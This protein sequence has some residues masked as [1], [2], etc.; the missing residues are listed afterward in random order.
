METSTELVP[1]SVG[2]LIEN[3]GHDR[4]ESAARAMLRL[5]QRELPVFDEFGPGVYLRTMFIPAGT[6]IIG[7][8]HK[9][10][11]F[12][13][14]LKGSGLIFMD[15]VVTRVRAPATFL[16]EAG[17]QKIGYIDEDM[18]IQGIFPTDETDL[19]K[20]HAMLT[21]PSPALEEHKLQ[22]LRR[23]LGLATDHPLVQE[24]HIPICSDSPQ[25]K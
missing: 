4:I 9:T 22:F 2:R 14:V 1:V 15:G 3:I 19:A 24:S 8:V 10:K 16:S 11:H 12:N 21:E 7:L 13:N 25:S 17:C 5:P 18:I 20:L 6:L 23:N